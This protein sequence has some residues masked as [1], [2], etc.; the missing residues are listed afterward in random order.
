MTDSKSVW[1]PC[2]F[3]KEAAQSDYDE[4]AQISPVPLDE[5]YRRQRAY[6]RN[7]SS[8]RAEICGGILPSRSK[9]QL[10]PSL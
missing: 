4:D 5:E 7:P 2:S 8:K 1:G 9:C 10:R 3:A 6:D